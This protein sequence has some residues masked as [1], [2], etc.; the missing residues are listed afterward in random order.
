MVVVVVIGIGEPNAH[1]L[2]QKHHIGEFVPGVL[3]GHK[4][5]INVGV[6]RSLL[7]HETDETAASG[8]AV[9]PEHERRIGDIGID[10]PIMDVFLSPGKSDVAAELADRGGKTGQINNLVGN[11]I[12]CVSARQ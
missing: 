7:G 9:G 2:L 6:K 4:V 3:I 10:K 12:G 11:G 5:A 8:A 1:W